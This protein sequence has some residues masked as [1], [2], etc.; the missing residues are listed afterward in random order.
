MTPGRVWSD[1]RIAELAEL[2]PEHPEVQAVRED[3]ER[4]ARLIAL[5][6]FLHPEAPPPGA[7][8]EEA[9]SRIR[10]A[11]QHALEA[12]EADPAPRPG[13]TP[14]RSARAPRA[15]FTGWPALAAAAAVIVAVALL[16][17]RAL[18]H[19]DTLRGSAATPLAATARIE[20]DAAVFTWRAVPGAEV[21][22]FA[23]FGEDLTALRPVLAVGDTVLWLPLDALRTADG[24]GRTLLWRVTAVHAGTPLA[25]S[26]TVRLDV[27]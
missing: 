13:M 27:P 10:A 1:E 19:R 9:V 14:A 23:V 20:G 8:T 2:P 24:A 3:P 15:W 7:R 12:Q 26:R 25:H 4:W 21:Y 5:R 22:E 6:A 18:E 17:P 16:L 11:V